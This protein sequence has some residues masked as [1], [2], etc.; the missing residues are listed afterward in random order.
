M[1][2][3]DL[4]TN[5]LLAQSLWLR[6]LARA[7]TGDAADDVL[8]ETYAAALVSPPRPDQ[9]LRPWL[10]AVVRN[11]AHMMFR[12]EGRRRAREA[13]ASETAGTSLPTPEELL[14][15]HQAQRLVA[16]AVEALEEP[17]R[18]TV[19]LCYVE[20]L[21]PS[22]VARRQGVP[23]GTVRWRLKR[24]LERIRARLE[25]RHGGR[26]GLALALAPLAERGRAAERARP[27]EGI[28]MALK[29]VT[30]VTLL[31]L[32]AGLWSAGRPQR[33]PGAHWSGAVA[34]TAGAAAARALPAFQTAPGVTDAAATID[35]M[36]RDETGRPVQGARVAAIAAIPLDDIATGRR[37]FG[38]AGMVV[39]DGAGRFR[40]ERL[41]PGSFGV[42]ATAAGFAPGHHGAVVVSP[43][44]A[45]HADL[46]L[47]RGAVTQRGRTLDAGG[48][49]VA[50]ARV[51]ALDFSGPAPDTTRVFVA[52]SD[53]SGR[54]ELPLARRVRYGFAAEADGY[55]QT[56]LDV[57]S[58]TE[59]RVRDIILKPAGQV[60]GRV[61]A[62][63]RP[64]AGAMVRLARQDGTDIP[65]VVSAVTDVQGEFLLRGVVPAHY[66]LWARK[67][68]DAGR[69]EAP[70]TVGEAEVVRNLSLAL[71]RRAV[72][73]GRVRSADGR[74]LAG[75]QLWFQR[76]EG[77][78][79]QEPQTS[80]DEQGD[81]RIEGVLPGS[82]TLSASAAGHAGE[83]RQ[84]T[85]D[86]TDLAGMDY[87]L[88][89]EARLRG[90][91]STAEGRA[92]PGVRVVV[93]PARRLGPDEPMFVSARTSSD[94]T[95]HL[96]GL[97]PGPVRVGAEDAELGLARATTVWTLVGGETQEVSLRLEPGATLQGRVRRPDGGP[98]SGLIVTAYQGPT[99]LATI[100]RSARTSADGGFL[101]RALGN[102]TVRLV[103]TAGEL[104]SEPRSLPAGAAVATVTL[105]EGRDAR[106]VELTLPRAP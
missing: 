19:L 76:E 45:A 60:S 58:L 90:R 77:T 67:G 21:S 92:A 27:G 8:Q 26:R 39:T 55:A 22:E 37:T 59:D 91:L 34:G 9:P 68:K 5:E 85:V 40:L 102:G 100:T 43:A 63:G 94:G 66:R 4:N 30:G 51:M 17:F 47:S 82:Y 78:V 50:A 104:I 105:A 6:R 83:Q 11:F 1:S 7:L 101:L 44:G 86:A 56:R 18:S 88:S 36:V 29:I 80:T 32:V 35:G 31:G 46:V 3:R 93:L 24:A 69:L 70:L 41:V 64:V 73:A 16:E 65:F 25:E 23:A 14:A 89:P 98:A 2:A 95:F 42:T 75:A 84:V 52:I 57:E 81:Y 12:S 103:A 96:E 53:G 74:P 20:G 79:A 33:S 72:I 49:A 62:S 71:E 38:P 48:G 13:A 106:D 15:S 61:V 87:R 10:A 97:H 54:Y 99:G 28:P